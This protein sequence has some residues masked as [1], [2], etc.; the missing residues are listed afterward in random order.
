MQR[1]PLARRIDLLDEALYQSYLVDPEAFA[2]EL[3]T[4]S[5]GGGNQG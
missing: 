3:R 2:A 4:L 1:F 5:P